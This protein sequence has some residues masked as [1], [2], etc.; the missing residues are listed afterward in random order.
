MPDEAA[1]ENESTKR[2]NVPF[3][4]W[5]R[6]L[7]EWRDDTKVYFFYVRYRSSFWYRSIYSYKSSSYLSSLLK[8]FQLI[9]TLKQRLSSDFFANSRYILLTRALSY[10]ITRIRKTFLDDM[11]QYTRGKIHRVSGKKKNSNCSDEEKLER[12]RWSR[13][14]REKRK[15]RRKLSSSHRDK[16]VT[17]RTAS[18]LKKNRQLKRQSKMRS[19]KAFCPNVLL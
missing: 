5:C 10:L 1:T 7:Y 6:F 12:S 4:A 3:N 16:C 15:D 17:F 14:G 9:L 2:K 8:I 13:I 18:Q 11:P 19:R